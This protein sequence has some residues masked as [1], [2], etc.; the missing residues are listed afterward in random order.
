VGRRGPKPTEIGL[1]S[2]WE[3]EFYKAFHLLRDG[4]QL[5]SKYESPPL[6]LSPAEMRRFIQQLKTMTPEDYWLTTNRVAVELGER[7]NL[8]KPPTFVDRLW[9]EQQRNDEIFWLEHALK[10]A[11]IQAWKKRR[12]IWTD[13]LRATTYASLRKACGRWAR[14][15]DI[16]ALGMTPFPEHVL[17]NVAQF[18]AMKQNKRFPTSNYGDDARLE[19]LA[20]GMAGVLAGISPMTGIERLRNMNHGVGGPMWEENGQYCKCWRCRLPSSTA[21][22]K[23][24]STWYANGLRLFMELAT[25]TKAP[26]DWKKRCVRRGPF[27]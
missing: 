8:R 7:L 12:K 16:R 24:T 1:L 6:A 23:K 18:F 19:Y 11:T 27:N 3:F 20:R 17:Q 26:K 2:T 10:P 22:E 9:A 25:T 15:P 4:R 13:L 21:A 14:L 5:P